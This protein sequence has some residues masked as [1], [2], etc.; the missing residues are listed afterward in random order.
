MHKLTAMQL[1]AL[2][3]S[4]NISMGSAATALSHLLGHKVEITTPRLTY[5]TLEKVRASYPLPCILIRV[6]YHKGLEGSNLFILSDRDAGMVAN[7]MMGDPDLP[8]PDELDDLYLSAVSEAMNQMMGSSATAMSEMFSRVVDITPPEIEYVNLAADTP[9]G[10]LADN[11]EVIQIA[12]DLKVGDYISSQMLQILTLDFAKQLVDELLCVVSGES[13]PEEPALSADEADTLAEIG[14]IFM[15]SAATALSQLLTKQVNITTPRVSI[16]TLRQIR[17]QFPEPC[18]VVT[19]EYLQGLTGDNLLIISQRDATVIAALMMG[20]EADS[21]ADLDEIRISAVSEAMNQMA[22]AACTS[23]AE[24]FY[25]NIEISPPQTEYRTLGE[26][27]AAEKKLD[28]LLVKLSFRLRVNGLIDSEIV[29]LIPFIFAREMVRVLLEAMGGTPQQSPQF[30]FEPFPEPAPAPEPILAP[31]DFEPVLAANVPHWRQ[32]VVGASYQEGTVQLDLIRDIPVQ[33]TGLLGRRTV[34]LK[35][36]MAV[37]AGTV[38]EL[39]STAEVPVDILANGKL[40]ARGEVVVYNNRFG[41]KIT[42]IIEP[43]QRN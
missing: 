29:Q 14:N 43:W 18:V 32:E 22:G 27:G 35:E 41:I 5:T 34:K 6:R 40:V 20:E 15:G 21:P 13:L 19:V 23:L 16:S 2:A 8:L 38:L 4:G 17:D 42:D 9:I 30:A 3:E 31:L 25:R 10:E 39:E 12:F 33:V 1:D 26:D 7:M 24:I 11:V 37:S 36:L 28:E